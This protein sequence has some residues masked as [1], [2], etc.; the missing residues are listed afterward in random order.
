MC[1]EGND[2]THEEAK[3]L[4]LYYN[5]TTSEMGMLQEDVVYRTDLPFCGRRAAVWPFESCLTIKHFSHP[6]QAIV[7]SFLITLAVAYCYAAPCMYPGESLE[8][9]SSQDK[10]KISGV[11]QLDF[12]VGHMLVLKEDGKVYSTGQ[13]TEGQLG[14]GAVGITMERG[15]W[16]QLYHVWPLE[17]T[18]M[19]Q[20]S[21]GASH[22]AAVSDK[23]DLYTW[24]RG[25]EG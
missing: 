13:G 8:R 7:T 10:N 19:R 24:G 22:S 25:F 20:I 12:G 23:G 18:K 15:D 9:S 17:G 11:R 6:I 3:L 2:L 14:L 5:L 1:L 16:S 21:C 4:L